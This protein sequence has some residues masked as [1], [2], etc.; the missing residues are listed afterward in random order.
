MISVNRL[1]NPVP[2]ELFPLIKQLYPDMNYE[3]FLTYLSDMLK[4]GYFV[5]AAYDN[6]KLI[7]L[8]GCWVSTKFYCGRFLQIDNLIVSQE[9][10]G[11]AIGQKIMDFVFKE[12]KHLNCESIILNVYEWNTKAHRFYDKYN[13][14]YL[15]K[16]RLLKID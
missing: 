7:A 8:T 5:I 11:N 9:Y 4:S 13:F 16:H 3:K 14:E 15:G 2:E 10:R 12:A 6:Q 1:D